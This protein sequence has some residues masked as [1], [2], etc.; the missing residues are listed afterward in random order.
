MDP[1]QTPAIKEFNELL[2]KHQALQFGDFT[3]KS[4]KKTDFFVNIGCMTSG[5]TIHFFCSKL[6]EMIALHHP[7][8]QP[9]LFGPAYKGIPLAA[10]CSLELLHLTN[11]NFSFAYNRK[12]KKT[13]G[14]TGWLAGTPVKTGDHA[15]IVEDVLTMGTSIKESMTTLKG[16]G[17]GVTKAYVILDREEKNEEDKFIRDVLA[18][19]QGIEIFSLFRRRD[20]DFP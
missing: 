12:E 11:R 6:A 10:V 2:F 15:I 19:K 13:H 3:T 20:I 9:L 18:E 16:L 17:V 14:E 5:E 1:E 7:Y 4:G 8:S